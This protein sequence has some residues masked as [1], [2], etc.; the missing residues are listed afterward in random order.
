MP[1]LGCV[2]YVN[3]IPL[4]LRFEEES[5]SVDVLYDVPSALPA[6]L[7]AGT[8]QAVLCSSIE[9]LRRADRGF[10]RTAS[11]STFGEVMSVRLFSNVPFDR[12]E[13]LA[14]DR[15]SMTSNALAQIVLAER[16]GAVPATMSAPPDLSAMLDQADACVMIGDLGMVARGAPYT[17]D[18][19]LEWRAMTDLPFVWALWISA[20]PI[21]PTL[22]ET[23]GAARAWGVERL[24]LAVRR[25]AERTAWPRSLC[26]RYLGEVMDYGFGPDHQAGLERFGE[27]LRS[28]GLIPALAA[29]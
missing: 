11:I 13:R 24:E 29:G 18:L 17:L 10:A 2:P 9:A 12:I 3:A 26:A 19:G 6:M 4:V 21:D 20:G 14:L 22:E 7:E 5:T 28:H 16:Y 8:A 25:A 23:L 27:A 15:S 1:T